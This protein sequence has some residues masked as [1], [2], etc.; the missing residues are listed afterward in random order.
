M[1]NRKLA[2]VV[3]LAVSLSLEGSEVFAQAASINASELASENAASE[4][5][6]GE[7]GSL[8]A[9]QVGQG[10][11]GRSADAVRR[12]FLELL[13]VER[14]NRNS[15]MSVEDLGERRRARRS[16]QDRRNLPPPVHVHLRPRFQY[17]PLAAARVTAD[18][19]SRISAILAA[20]DAG[21]VRVVVEDRKATLI[22]SVRS[23][24]E[25]L[26]LAKLAAIEPGIS[27]VENRITI[28]EVLVVP[29][30][31]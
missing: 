26:L 3:M 5:F 4:S 20:R 13:G 7:Q 18:V 23:E 21:T 8:E 9:P 2:W 15:D 16:R 10:P 11:V 19:Q 1:K 12:N 22:G 6:S 27:R 29:A 14:R 28:E 17:E 25:R 31:Q 24:Y 30:L